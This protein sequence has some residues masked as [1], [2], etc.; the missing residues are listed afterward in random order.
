MSI[1]FYLVVY[2]SFFI[3]SFL[4]L[5]NFRKD[6]F[7]ESN[8][9]LKKIFF[10]TLFSLFLCGSLFSIFYFFWDFDKFIEY[11][12]FSI[13][14]IFLVIYNSFLLSLML[15][16][17]LIEKKYSYFV[18]S[19]LYFFFSS[20]VFIFYIFT[21]TYFLHDKISSLFISHTLNER[22]FLFFGSFFLC[23]FLFFYLFLSF[24][25]NWEKNIKNNYFNIFNFQFKI[26]NL[27]KIN[28]FLIFISFWFFTESFAEH[29]KYPLPQFLFNKFFSFYGF[30]I[31]VGFLC[32]IENFEKHFYEKYGHENKIINLSIFYVVIIIFSLLGAKLFDDYFISGELPSIKK[33]FTWKYVERGG[34]SIFGGVIFGFIGF[35]LYYFL[36]KPKILIRDFIDLAVPNI[37]IGQSIG[38]WGNFMNVENYGEKVSLNNFFWL[39]TL[40]KKQMQWGKDFG[41]LFQL[42]NGYIH[43]P[44]FLIE[45]VINIIGYFVIRFVDKKF[46]RYLSKGDLCCLYF[47]WYGLIRICL[48]PLR[49]R[50]PAGGYNEISLTTAIIFF[51]AGLISIVFLHVYDFIRWK[52]Y[53]FFVS[54]NKF[55][56][57][58]IYKE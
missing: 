41:K 32:A 44:L 21:Y 33:F 18:S 4:L 30:I 9:N 6:I 56:D 40:I 39:P 54:K 15:F 26:D 13:F 20:F 22:F 12:F 14:F 8:L 28:F 16:F 1:L 49:E 35:L 55:D 23:L 37:L 57:E 46:K 51:V 7:N 25:Q 38:R 11:K 2:L 27:K 45:S 53:T 50:T 24:I 34:F 48:E 17:F 5:F 19:F 47:I 36:F 10:F 52:K 29:I 3:L 58:N 43:L 31:A 42:D